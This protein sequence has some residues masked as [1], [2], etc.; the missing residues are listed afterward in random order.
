M[1]DDLTGITVVSLEQAVAAPFASCK[2]ADAGAT[3]IKI[4]RSE[5]DFARRYDRMAKGQ[6]AYFVWLNRG[7]SSVALDIKDPGDAQ[8][9]LKLI[10]RADVFIQNLS[11]GA[12]ARAGFAHEELRKRNPRLITCNIS[13]Y[14][15]DGP[16][17]NMK[18]YDLLVQAESGLCDI[19]GPPDS[20]S[21]VGVSV[22][23]IAGGMYA[24][25][26][27]LQALYRREQC[28]EGRNIDV[29]LF[30]AMA[31]WMTVPL[32]QQE[33]GDTALKRAGL[34]HLT[35]APYGS[36]LCKDKQHVLFSIQNEREWHRF[37]CDVIEDELMLAD[38]RFA[39][40]TSRVSNRPA[41]DERIAAAL[42]KLPRETVIRRF[43]ESRIAYGLL[44]T[45]DDL[46]RHPQL[47]RVSVATPGG[48]IQM[49]APPA[50]IGGAELKIRAVPEVGEGNSEFF[51]STTMGS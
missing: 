44:N 16:Y 11:V 30:D 36:Y 51:R 40:N 23:D 13:G 14:G 48:E 32:L 49:P 46:I 18:A 12:A 47:R 21:R 5:G 42:T 50:R 31:D 10:D 39:D 9:L 33:Y 35:I 17:R 25:A 27:I 34:H 3:V 29:S 15:T 22:S 24:H 43:D 2:L 6:S 37:C 26:A 45:V 38:E 41:L 8:S 4:E 19:T 1:L 7:K 20:P 28:N